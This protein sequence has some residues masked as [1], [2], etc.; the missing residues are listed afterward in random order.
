MKSF[1]HRN[2]TNGFTLLELLVVIAVLGVLT[3]LGL[4]GFFTLTSSWNQTRTLTELTHKADDA[5]DLIGRDVQDILSAKLSG[6]SVIGER[7][8]STNDSGVKQAT[9]EDDRIVLQLQG[10]HRGLSLQ[11][12]TSVQYAVQ[13][14]S[15]SPFLTRTIGEFG[16]D[17]PNQNPLRP[18]DDAHTTRFR[19]EYNNGKRWVGQWSSSEL[20]RAIRVSL[21]VANPNNPTMQVARKRVFP[22]KV[23]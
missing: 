13:R 16:S 22:V 2:R 12:S 5:L 15:G 1:N 19:V 10:I 14:G 21:T 23:Q 4:R 8:E 11:K 20:P 7:R 9:D 17:R 3:T 18:I 6:Q